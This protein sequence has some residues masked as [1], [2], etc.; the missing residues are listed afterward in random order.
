[1]NPAPAG[2]KA[3]TNGPRQL[4]N[5]NLRQKQ[6]RQAAPIMVATQPQIDANPD[7]RSICLEKFKLGGMEET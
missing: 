6:G 7:G 2:K 3:W 4:K 5:S 1:M